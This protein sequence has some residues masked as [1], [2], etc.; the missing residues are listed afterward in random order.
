MRI[1]NTKSGKD[2]KKKK[3]KQSVLEKELYSIV[4]KSLDAAI[5][6]ALDDIFKDWNKK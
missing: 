2:R 1:D 5:E 4:A 6:L 3:R